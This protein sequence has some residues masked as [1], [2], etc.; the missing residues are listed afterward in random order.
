MG[1]VLPLPFEDNPTGDLRI[2]ASKRMINVMFKWKGRGSDANGK[3]FN[4]EEQV[5]RLMGA[6]AILQMNG[7]IT[8]PQAEG[9]IKHL[10]G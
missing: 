2:C 10:H 7:E 5:N 8:Q 1:N 3:V 4:F 9:I 6:I